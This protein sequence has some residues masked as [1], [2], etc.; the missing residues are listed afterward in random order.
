M[1][2]KDYYKTLGVSRTASKDEIKKAY[3]RLARKYHPDVSKVSNAEERFKD[4][5]EAYEV[6][7]DDEKRRIYDQLGTYQPGQEFRPPPDW[8]QHFGNAQGQGFSGFESVDLG[9]LFEN[10][11]GQGMG[12]VSG[13]AAGNFRPAKHEYRTEMFVSLDEAAR[14]VERTLRPGDGGRDVKVRIPKGVT[15]GQVLRVPRGGTARAGDILI[16]VRLEPHPRFKVSGHDL[17]IDVP[18]AP[19]EAVLGAQIEIPTLEKKV[20]LTV[21]P[22]SQ[23]GGKL[24]LKGKGL[25]RRTGGAGDLIAS[26]QVMVPEHPGE[27]ERELY[28]KLRKHSDFNPRKE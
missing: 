2:Y 23:T 26:L 5:G 10:L 15:D 20:L 9:D 7:R 25:P 18:I 6:L 8:A 12:G 16:T 14:G 13:G 28:E 19:W 17:L 24:R 21:K 3:R 4:V 11:F 27:K 1:K 22:G